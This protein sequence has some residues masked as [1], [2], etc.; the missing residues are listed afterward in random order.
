MPGIVGVLETSLYVDSV[1]RSVEYYQSLFSFPIL[2]NLERIASLRVNDRQV[3]LLFKKGGS[4]QP[5]PSAEGTIPPH[6]GSGQNHIAFSIPADDFE[7]WQHVLAEREIAIEK[8]INWESG[9]RSLYFR[10]LDGHL[11]ELATPGIW[12]LR[13]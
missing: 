12:D 3:L 10:D 13:W 4:V 7:R 1:Q 9:S 11:V 5:I 6:D 8:I 2:L